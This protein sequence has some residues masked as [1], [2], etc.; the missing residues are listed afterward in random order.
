[1]PTN[2]YDFGA[3]GIS[4]TKVTVDW[5]QSDP[6]RIYRLLR[7]LVQQRLIGYRLLTGRVDLT[8]TGSGI[9]EISESI[10]SEQ[11]GSIVN[12]LT[13]Y[14]LTGA[15][16]PTLATVKPNKTGLKT[17]ISDEAIA[18][19][20]IDKVM[21]DLIKIAN[22][23]T[24][25][26]DAVALA[27]IASAVTKTTA[28]A[29]SWSGGSANPFLDVLLADASIDEENQGYSADTIVTTPT[30]FAYAISRATV[31]NYLPRE[32]AGNVIT[33]DVNSITLA[34]KTWLKTPNMPQGVSAIVLDSTMLGSLA[35]ERLGGGYQGDPSDMASGVESKRYRLEDSDGVSVQARIV[36]A[37]M[38]Q[39]PNAARVL[40]GV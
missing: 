21:R 33:N 31:L 4:G 27:A 18:H 2:D 40:T 12:P 15:G 19:N 24:F 7:T 26:S 1:M 8:G 25:Q 30:N 32:Q 34:G 13:E 22:Q 37:P 38:V 14:P 6:R 36:R 23:L 16:V 20:R 10:F 35:F 29:G 5:L 11:S 9:Y 28:A 39:E 17:D 3:P